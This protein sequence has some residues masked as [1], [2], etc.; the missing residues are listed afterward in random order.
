M[1]ELK[2]YRD[3]HKLSLSTKSFALSSF[4]LLLTASATPAVAIGQ[5]SDSAGS[6]GSQTAQAGQPDFAP[7]SNQ[8]EQA[9]GASN[10]RLDEARKKVCEQNQNRIQNSF[11]NINNRSESQLGVMKKIANRVQAFAEDK[12]SKPA[13][14]DK[15][16][17]EVNRT[18]TEAQNAVQA[19]VQ[20]SSQFGCD[21]DD[22]K[23]TASQYKVQVK[24]H[25]A[26]MKEY[27]NAINNLITAVKTA[28]GAADGQEAQE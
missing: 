13:N 22:P 18:R 2:G 17:A 15:L 23:G 28:A 4:V 20:T 7:Q 16:V 5:G 27:K 11:Q 1:H 3:M 26:A 14:Y 19:S 25:I 12:N 24:A 6:G 8:S 9:Q 10:G 21:S